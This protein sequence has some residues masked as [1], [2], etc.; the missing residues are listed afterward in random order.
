[1]H[2]INQTYSQFYR[3]QKEMLAMLQN[4]HFEN[5]I[6]KK[7]IMDLAMSTLSCLSDNLL[8]L[9]CNHSIDFILTS[10]TP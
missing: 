6:N 2:H 8:A 5:S 3:S 10:F 9:D 7:W 1:M 4:K